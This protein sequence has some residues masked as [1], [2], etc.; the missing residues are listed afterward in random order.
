M[1]FYQSPHENRVSSFKENPDDIPVELSDFLHYIFFNWSSN[2]II[3]KI[4]E[5]CEEYKMRFEWKDK[6]KTFVCYVNKNNF[7]DFLSL[8]AI[9]GNPTTWE[10]IRE[11]PEPEYYGF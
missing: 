5:L 4:K 2:M 9:L 11:L 1:E 3:P 10:E 6:G 8:Y 7:Q